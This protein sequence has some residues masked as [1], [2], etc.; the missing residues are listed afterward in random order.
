MKRLD[1]RHAFQLRTIQQDLLGKATN[2]DYLIGK[3]TEDY[4]NYPYFVSEGYI[5]YDFSSDG[6][7]KIHVYDVFA[8][9]SDIQKTYQISEDGVITLIP[10][11]SDLSGEQYTIVKLTKEKMEWQRVGTT[12]QKGSLSSDFKHFVRKK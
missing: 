5:N 6:M 8:G 2:T 9:E 1:L 11:E 7:V 4:S 10:E 12:F 3:W